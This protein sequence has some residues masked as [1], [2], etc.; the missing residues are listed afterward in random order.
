ML[1]GGSEFVI[2]FPLADKKAAAAPTDV[3]AA[4]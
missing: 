1:H 2:D 3:N 4:A